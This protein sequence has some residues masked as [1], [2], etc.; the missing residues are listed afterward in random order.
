MTY[1][2]NTKCANCFRNSEA[3]NECSI[4]TSRIDKPV[5][6][7]FITKQD[8]LTNS[9]NAFIRAEN[10]GCIPKGY[11]DGP[12]FIKITTDEKGNDIIK[13]DFGAWLEWL[14]DRGIVSSAWAAKHAI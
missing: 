12:R 3:K 4:L 6:P 9:H 8:A 10:A 11:Y 5:C 1:C 7:F 2:D 14:A 13:P